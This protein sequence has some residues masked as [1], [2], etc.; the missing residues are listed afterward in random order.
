MTTEVFTLDYFDKV[1]REI[2]ARQGLMVT[3]VSARSGEYCFEIMVKQ[4]PT[5]SVW[6][7]IN[8]SIDVRT[9][10]A[11]G[12]GENSIRGWL[13]DRNGAPLGNK[14][15]RW[16]TRVSG[17]QQR[18]DDMLD[19]LIVMARSINYCDTCQTLEKVFITKN[20]PNK[21]RL[22]KKCEC[23]RS[24]QWLDDD[25]PAEVVPSCPKCSR[26]MVKRNG[27]NGEFWGC[28]S[29][30]TCKGTRNLTDVGTSEA[31]KVEA[32]NAFAPSRYQQAIFNH[33][34]AW[35]GE[36][37][38]SMSNTL[39]INALAGS[40]KT[41]TGKLMMQRLPKSMKGLSVAYNNHIAKELQNVM[42]SHVKASTVH[43]LGFA[44]CRAGLPKLLK[45]DSVDD[46]KGKL[47][48]GN[49]ID[50]RENES[51]VSVVLSLVSFVKATLGDA[52]DANL[53]QISAFYDVD[54]N[55]NSDFI[56]ECVRYVVAKSADVTTIIDYDDMVWLPVMLDLPCQK[57]DFI[58]VDEA[59]D[60]NACDLQLIKKHAHADTKFVFVGDRYQSMYGF[61]GADV[62]SIPNIITAF[63]AYELPL[64]ITYRSPKLMVDMVGELFPEIGLEAR[65][66]AIQGEYLKCSLDDALSQAAVGDMFLCRMNA[67]LVHPCMELIRK[68]VKAIIRGR[69]I[70]KGLLLMV[71]KMRAGDDINALVVAL[72]EYYQ[73][74]R[75]KFMLADKEYLAESLR[76]RVE[77]IVALAD[78]VDTVAGLEAKIARI[79]SDDN[80]GV[81]FSSVHRAKGL[82]TDNVYILQPDMMP[83]PKAKP[84]WQLQQERNIQY[85]ALTRCKR[86]LIDVI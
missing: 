55:G 72:T 42:P 28:P 65:P 76:D 12:T 22:F 68:G 50:L 74:E 20:G 82:E 64:S 40:G 67:P 70:G 7:Y 46:G 13:S 21:G 4:F 25:K 38:E 37:G 63:T 6:L 58:F 10:R 69:D 24:F 27:R 62:D 15:Q 23:T 48:L 56:F 36:S 73:K 18:L 71:R 78:G 45:N 77:T 14:T 51:I 66:D 49:Y 53:A 54:L 80:E 86:R 31:P 81:V 16:V 11:A 3:Q 33:M 17:W 47:L 34:D 52:S 59:Q 83:H 41:T 1:L 44:A 39:V 32:K 30:P 61:R 60:L 19:K 79:F 2:C 8:S 57:Y 26:N 43:S 5:N 85:V 75:V 84:G 9:Q 35:F 29:Y